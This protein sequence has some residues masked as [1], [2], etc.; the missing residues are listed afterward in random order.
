MKARAPLAARRQKK[1]LQ[2]RGNDPVREGRIGEP[3]EA[4]VAGTLFRA[5]RMLESIGV[6]V[7][8]WDH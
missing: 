8:P 5:A 1:R 6:Q 3:E 2:F 4:F 7:I